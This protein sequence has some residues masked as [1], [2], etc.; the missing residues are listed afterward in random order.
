MESWGSLPCSQETTTGPYPELNPVHI[1]KRHFVKIQ[2][3]TT[4][5]GNVP[6]PLTEHHA[7]KAYSGVEV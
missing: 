1:I 4:G 7:I 5:K 3:L 6:V 2:A